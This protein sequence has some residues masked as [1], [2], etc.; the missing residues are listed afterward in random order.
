MSCGQSSN[1]CHGSKQKKNGS[2]K[3]HKDRSPHTGQKDVSVLSTENTVPRFDETA[4]QPDEVFTRTYYPRICVSWLQRW[5]HLAALMNFSRKKWNKKL[6]YK[7]FLP[8]NID[9]L[10]QPGDMFI[11]L[12][13]LLCIKTRQLCMGPR[14][15]ARF[16]VLEGNTWQLGQ[17]A[18]SAFFS[19]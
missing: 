10:H 18:F 2:A 17:G 15:S 11:E 13:W 12:K 8:I 4:P 16:T 7:K 9:L 3:L 5:L 6:E 1:G 19:P 14:A